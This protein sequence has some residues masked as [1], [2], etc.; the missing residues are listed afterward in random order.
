[1]NRRTIQ[2]VIMLIAFAIGLPAATAFAEPALPT[3]SQKAV[4]PSEAD[5]VDAPDIIFTNLLRDKGARYNPDASVP[6]AGRDAGETET[7]SAIR[8]VPREDVQAKVLSAAIG[9]FSGAKSIT[10]GIYSDNANLNTVGDPLPGGQATTSKIPEL[11]ECCQLTT[12]TLAGEGVFLAKGQAYWLVAAPD[13]VN[14][15]TFFGGWHDSFHGVSANRT[16]PFDWR[17]P[18]GAW[19]AAEIRGTKLRTS[20]PVVPVV[21]DLAA[22]SGIIFSNL[23]RNSPYLFLYGAGALVAGNRA[24]FQPE[25]W[26]ALPFTPRS[27]MHAQTLAAA[28]AWTSGTKLLNLGIYSDD[29]GSPGTPLLGGQGNTSKIPTL[30]DCCQLMQVRLPGEGVA[31]SKGVQYWL[32]VSPDNAKAADFLGAWQDSTLAISAYQQPENFINWTTYSGSWLAAEIRGT[33][34]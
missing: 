11:G 15:A 22:R 19:S 10:L 16:P 29:A 30:G 27:D 4:A 1:M 24:A 12:V 14:G 34:P 3:K 17:T 21:P 13:D 31:L 8:F 18:S 25:S 23:D 20:E 32:V 9:H 7:W 28:I 33:S 2:Y 26:Q 5:A 6:I